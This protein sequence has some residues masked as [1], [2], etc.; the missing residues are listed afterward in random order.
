MK[1]IVQDKPLPH[2]TQVVEDG[3]IEHA[4]AAGVE[5]RN[6]RPLAII[7][8]DEADTV[9]GGLVAAT[10]WGWLHV[11]ECW[12]AERYRSHGWGARLLESAEREA[13]NRQCHHVYLDTF[14]FQALGFYERLGYEIFGTLGDFPQGHTRYFVKKSLVDSPRSIP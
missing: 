8:Y 2:D 1:M 9:V 14:D 5:P 4:L 7:L 10:V 3:L 11:Q 12:V 6:Y 13:M